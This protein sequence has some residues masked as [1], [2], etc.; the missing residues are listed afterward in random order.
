ML[1]YD[2]VISHTKT[3]I[4][5]A[6]IIGL[7]A[8]LFYLAS[9]WT[10]NR[11]PAQQ[12]SKRAYALSLAAWLLQG[13]HLYLGLFTEVGL[14]L[15]L[16]ATLSLTTWAVIGVILISS[17][18][19]PVANLLI[20]AAPAAA[21]AIVIDILSVPAFEGRQFSLGILVHIFTSILA[22]ALFAVAACQAV[23]LIYQNRHLK[24]HQSSRLVTSL[25]PLQT[26]E[27]LLFEVLA[28]GQILLSMALLTGF[29]FL[30]DLW[31]QH[32][33]HKTIL[34]LVAWFIFTILLYGHYRLGWRGRTAIR[35]TL[36]GF[37][38]LALAFFGTKMVLELLL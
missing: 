24:H 19:N 1:H 8:V 23:L 33:A 22:Y 31:A 11:T 21:A 12:A 20:F 2:G 16:G 6:L 18:R 4:M 38:N 36:W 26:M 32:V 13:L 17:L 28:T 27:S 34:S 3:N 10:Q 37:G 35:W 30:D 5:I 15:D 29:L 25:P 14:L 7:S 9:A